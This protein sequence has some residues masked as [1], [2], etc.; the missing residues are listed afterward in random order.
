MAISVDARTPGSQTF[1]AGASVVGGTSVTWTHTLGAGSNTILLAAGAQDA[2]AASTSAAWDSAGTNVAMTRET[3][4][5]ATGTCRPEIWYLQTPATTGSK[6]VKVSWSGSHDGG[7]SSASYFGVAGFNAS[8]PQN[9]TGANGTNPS[10]TVTSTSGEMVVDAMVQDFTANSVAPTKNASANYIGAGAVS[11]TTIGVGAS[12]RSSVG[13][14]VTMTWSV[15]TT[16]GAWSQTGVSL[17]VASTAGT[18]IECS[19]WLPPR[20]Q[21]WINQTY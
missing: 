21:P 7:Y 14:S 10:L 8:S 11:A 13:A 1:A 19:A 5:T 9:A 6:S 17:T 3:N 12:D 16:K 20:P 15:D 2:G 18:T 4:A